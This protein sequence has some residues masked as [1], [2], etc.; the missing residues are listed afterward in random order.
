MF[1]VLIYFA[2]VNVRLLHLICIQ[3]TVALF[4][5]SERQSTIKC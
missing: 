4:V 5:V 3:Y 1:S 2:S